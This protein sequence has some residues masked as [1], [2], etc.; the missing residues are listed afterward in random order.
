[1]K[2]EIILQPDGV[3][4]QIEQGKTILEAAR[5][6]GVDLRSAC[7][8]KGACGK[9]RVKVEKGGEHLSSPMEREIKILKNDLQSHYRL[10]CCAVITAPL[11]IRIPEESRPAETVILVEGETVP[12]T[13]DPAIDKYHINMTVPSPENSL[14]AGQSLSNGLAQTYGLSGVSIDDAVLQRLPGILRR[15]DGDITVTVWDDKAVID[16][17]P[18]YADDGYGIAVDI[19]TT[20]VVGY[21]INLRTGE[22]M[23]VDAM[24]NPQ[25]AYG[26]DVMTRIS[27]SLQNEKN[28]QEIQ[29]NIVDCINTIISNTCKSAEITTQNVAEMTIVGNTAMHHLFLGLDVKS[30]AGVPFAPVIHHACD[31]KAGQLGL[32]INPSANVHLLPL[33]GGFVG[34]DNVGVLIT[35]MPHQDPRLTVVIDI[36]TN[37]EI[38]VGNRELGLMSCSTAAG[39]AFE[40]AHIKFGMRAAPGAIEYI[41]IEPETCDVDY[42]TIGGIQPRGICGSGII[43]V[44]AQMLNCGVLLKNGRINTDIPTSRVRNSEDGPEFVLEWADKTAIGKDIVISQKDI[45]EVQLAKSA[46]YTG[47]NILMKRLGVEDVER[48]VLAGAFGSYVDRESAMAIGMFPECDLENV[49]TVGNAAGRGACMALLSRGKR[50]EAAEIAR[51][52][53]YVELSKDPDFE[54]IFVE[55]TQFL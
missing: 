34:A 29:N 38:V 33:E 6:L 28:R 40:G 54:S 18:G 52:V 30:L 42:H 32:S 19:G 39:P 20:T 25:I 23:A 16:V 4:G 24:A 5:E 2:H 43:D 10:A 49:V 55:S 21:L 13:M 48:V 8:G 22:E 17:E 7:G 36:G 51:A 45:R 11:T 27:Y 1:M 37:G 46:L 14:S 12:F 35:T 26:A 53:T 44:V 50:A 9:C 15:S 41:R 3:K 31:E 47:A